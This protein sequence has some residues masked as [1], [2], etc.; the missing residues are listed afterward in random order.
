MSS[1]SDTT[2]RSS[3]HSVASQAADFIASLSTRHV[4]CAAT[5]EEMIR[6]LDRPLPEHSTP[7]EL[8]I[9]DLVNDVKGGLV[10]SAGP[11]Y[12][13]FVVGG[14]TPASLMADW[15]TSAW[16]QNAQ[17]YATSPAAAAAEVIAAR[18]IVELLGLPVQS[19]V[20]LVTGCQMANF[21][22]LA[23]GRNAILERSGWDLNSRGLFGAKPITVFMSECGHATVRSA[24]HMMGIG[25]AQIHEIP[26]DSQGRMHL[27]TLEAEIRRASGQP[28]ILSV[29]AGNVN[30]GAFEPIEAIA[31]LVQAENAW[32]H[33]DGAFGLWAAVSPE[34]KTHLKGMERADSWATDA[35]KWL[36]VPYDSG[37]VIVKDQAQHRSLKTSR[38]AYAGE[39]SE[40]RR[41]GSS[42]APENS[43]RARA[44]VVYAVLRELGRTG[45]QAIV[46]RCCMLARFFARGVT[47]IPG[48]RV[49]NDVVLNQVL[50]RLES[51]TVDGGDAL[52][53]AVAAKMQA[54]GRCWL[55]TTTWKGQLALRVSICNWMTTEDDIALLLESLAH[56][57]HETAGGST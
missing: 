39:E 56:A 52:H 23:S 24:L 28:M 17:V 8:V 29:Q 33:V 26:S 57:V 54:E 44:F 3:L 25:S 12:F 21:T 19:S 11:R 34:L 46:E 35:H 31:D 7:A 43:R 14:A 15:L 5:P 22:A 6:K 45:V 2:I 32:L 16:D 30:S 1:E 27:S 4:G 51:T 47:Q 53:R 55:G 48:A 40:G 41:D 36:N 9:R 10:A 49:L 18:W 20:G 13:G 37:I 42:W 50:V 38:C